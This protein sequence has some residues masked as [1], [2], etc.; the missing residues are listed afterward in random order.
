MGKPARARPQPRSREFLGEFGAYFRGKVPHD[1]W[2]G[3][4]AR[5]HSPRLE[6]SLG[7]L[8]KN[9]DVAGNELEFSWSLIGARETHGSPL[10]NIGKSMEFQ[11]N[12]GNS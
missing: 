1:L 7:D 4:I 3:S 6:D 8:E 2:R 11:G 12:H 10:K 5:D 9:R